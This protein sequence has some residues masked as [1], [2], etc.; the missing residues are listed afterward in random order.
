MFNDRIDAGQQLAV[1]LKH[2]K[3]KKEAVVVALPRGGVILGYAIANELHLPLEVLM[4][5][6]IGHPTNPEFAIGAVSLTGSIVDEFTSVDETYIEK[7]IKNIRELLKK[8]Y[9]MYY[10]NKPPLELKNKTVIVVDDGVATGSTMIAALD[11]IKNEQ[12]KHIV[13]AVPVGPPDT[14]KEIENF[15]D[16]TICLETYSPFYSIG[17]YYKNFTQVTDNEVKLLLSMINHNNLVNHKK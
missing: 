2:Y 13:V 16:E 1:A 11:L 15:S 7:E 5:K 12:P 9:K 4:V 17:I 6:K 8:R 3:R 14:I 10:G